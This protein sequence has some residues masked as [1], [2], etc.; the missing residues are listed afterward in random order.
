FS[1]LNDFG[2]L[3]V[4]SPPRFHVE[5]AIRAVEGGVPVFLEKPVSP[6]AAS[7]RRL[8]G[9]VSRTGVPLLLGYTYRWWPPL[10]E[11]ARRIKANAV[12]RPLSARCVMSA[13]L[14]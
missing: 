8:S 11:M 4:C 3:V 1:K 9:V 7:A 2:G 6:D 10:Q 13:H 5:Q 14:A 12:G